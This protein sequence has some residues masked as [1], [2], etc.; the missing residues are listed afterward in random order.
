MGVILWVIYIYMQQPWQA[1]C[2]SWAAPSDWWY[3]GLQRCGQGTPCCSHG[4]R[5]AYWGVTHQEAWPWKVEFLPWAWWCQLQVHTEWAAGV[6]AALS[7]TLHPS[8]HKK[9]W[10]RYSFWHTSKIRY[11][12]W[13]SWKKFLTELVGAQLLEWWLEDLQN[14][15]ISWSPKNSLVPIPHVRPIGWSGTAKFLPL[16]K[17][18]VW[19]EQGLNSKCPK[20]RA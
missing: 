5:W 10:G 3:G 11:Q 4:S 20:Q 19:R 14:A 6:T 13:V 8:T 16:A 9:T 2:A 18:T 1:S 17:R 15:K 7:C 12:A